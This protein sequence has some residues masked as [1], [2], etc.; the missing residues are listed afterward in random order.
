MKCPSHVP[1]QLF[2]LMFKILL[3]PDEQAVRI[4]RKNAFVYECNAFY[5]RPTLIH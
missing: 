1:S 4:V 5:C 2:G 3:G